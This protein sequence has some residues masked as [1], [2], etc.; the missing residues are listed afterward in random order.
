MFPAE[1]EALTAWIMG[2]LT[3]DAPPAFLACTHTF[4]QRV[5]YVKIFE[6]YLE[7]TVVAVVPPNLLMQEHVAEKTIL[8]QLLASEPVGSKGYTAICEW[9][10]SVKRL[11]YNAET[12]RL[13]FTVKDQSVATKWHRQE[14]KLRNEKLLLFSTA[15]LEEEDNR[16]DI[17]NVTP[18]HA[19]VLQYQVRV[20]APGLGIDIIEQLIALSTECEV[21]SIAR[22]P[23]AKEETYDSNFWV[24]VFN[25][26]E[27]P[28]Q[29]KDVTHIS[30]KGLS[31][32]IH[33]HQRYSR[34]PCFQC[35][36]PTH[37]KSKCTRTVNDRQTQ[38]HRDFESEIKQAKK[39][40]TLEFEHM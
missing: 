28:P 39:L 30:A 5:T 3:L 23:R 29:I 27:C 17:N 32:F 20:V 22:E 4:I 21:I 16:S 19:T 34:I 31:I 7:G 33:H 24:V 35:Y 25:S 10:R 37:S 13:T 18:N 2:V 9:I 6:D 1:E 26:E 36:D 14:I 15:K 11:F 8:M 40:S 38:C 12:R